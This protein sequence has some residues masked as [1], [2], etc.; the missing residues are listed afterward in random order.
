MTELVKPDA[1]AF[2]AIV[3][4]ILLKAPVLAGME[5]ADAQKLFE[6]ARKVSWKTDDTIFTTNDIAI[7]M[8][9]LV[10]GTLTVWMDGIGMERPVAKL[11]P[12][13]SFGEMALVVGGKRTANITATSNAFALAF[14]PKELRTHTSLGMV[15]FKNISKILADR[16]KNTNKYL[17]SLHHTEGPAE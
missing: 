7:E 8:F 9:I 1:N 6:L 11:S 16:L 2:N 12:G 10:G 3:S 17:E 15:I 13:D 4:K 14:N 5:P